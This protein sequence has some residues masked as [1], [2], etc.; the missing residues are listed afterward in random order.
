[1]GKHDDITRFEYLKKNNKDFGAVL[2][3]IELQ[4][5]ND[6]NNIIEKMDDIGFQY[7][8]INEEDLLHTYLI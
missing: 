3:G 1:M 4:D 7:T 8:K 5:S 2:I 6:I